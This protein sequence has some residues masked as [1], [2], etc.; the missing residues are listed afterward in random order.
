[1]VKEIR[2][3]VITSTNKIQLHFDIIAN[4]QVSEDEA[5][6]QAAELRFKNSIA[7]AQQEIAKHY[8]KI[9]ELITSKK[10]NHKDSD[11][12]KKQCLYNK[13]LETGDSIVNNLR[14]FTVN[15]FNSLFELVK[16]IFNYIRTK[17]TNIISHITEG[18]KKLRQDYF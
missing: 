16:R 3:S 1:M 14:E 18:F 6:V 9:N 11:Y 15:V 5:E 10:P 4:R 17:A 2:S 12:R 8:T 13:L 7:K